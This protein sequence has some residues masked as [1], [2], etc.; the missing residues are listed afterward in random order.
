MFGG[1]RGGHKEVGIGIRKNCWEKEEV[2]SKHEVGM[3]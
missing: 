2:L 1:G 3:K